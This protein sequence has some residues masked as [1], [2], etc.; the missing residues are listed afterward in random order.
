MGRTTRTLAPN[1]RGGRFDLN[2][3]FTT[4]EEPCGRV[5]RLNKRCHDCFFWTEK[6]NSPPDDPKLGSLNLPLCLVNIRNPL[7]ERKPSIS[8]AEPK[9]K[10]KGM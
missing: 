5:T 6:T 9:P 7:R 3:D 8:H 1:A 10:K 2:F 4:P